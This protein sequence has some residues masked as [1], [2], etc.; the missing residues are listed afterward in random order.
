MKPGLTRLCR[1]VLSG[2]IVAVA[3]SVA[4]AADVKQ[5]TPSQPSAVTLSTQVSV[6][7]QRPIP[8]VILELEKRYGWIVT[9]EDPI[10]ESPKDVEEVTAVREDGVRGKTI[11]APRHKFFRFDYHN[12]DPAR[13]RE[14][15]SA[16]LAE[17][18]AAHDHAFRL[19]QRGDV[20]HIIP[21]RS[22]DQ[23]GI[24]TARRS[25]LD[26]RVNI[27]P[28]T[29]SVYDTLVLILEQV[30]K[31]GGQTV[32][33]GTPSNLLDQTVVQTG[34]VNEIA[35]DVLVRTLAGTGMKLSWTLLCT[36][37]TPRWCFLNLHPV[38]ADE[39]R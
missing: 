13:P 39:S 3:V 16:M 35:R 26:V 11:I 27:E 2:W 5:S 1:A 28:A 9:Y 21:T 6:V 15:L 24:P 31:S 7:S 34:A 30:S 32:N 22:P 4:L 14:L 18:E 8:D 19:V 25:R 20:F 37:R 38:Q 12:L 29:R 33:L 36:A 23:K 10:Y 17:Y